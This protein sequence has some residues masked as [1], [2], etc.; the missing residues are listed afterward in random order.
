MALLLYY[1]YTSVWFLI[2]IVI[3]NVSYGED[4]YF[5]FIYPIINL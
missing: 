3:D 5:G 4:V 2:G 1:I